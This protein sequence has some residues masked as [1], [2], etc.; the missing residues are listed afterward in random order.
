MDQSGAIPADFKVFQCLRGGNYCKIIKNYLPFAHIS[1]SFW[2][3]CAK[4]DAEV[5][6]LCKKNPVLGKDLNS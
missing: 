4:E 2:K 1:T 5:V 6:P 3:V